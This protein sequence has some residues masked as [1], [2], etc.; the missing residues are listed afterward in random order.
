MS[1][2]GWFLLLAREMMQFIHAWRS[3]FKSYENWL[4][5]ILILLSGMYLGLLFFNDV[6]ITLKQHLASWTLFFGWI[7]VTLLIGRFPVIGLLIHMSL[8]VIRQLLV[9]LLVFVPVMIAF[10][11]AFHVLLRSS[12]QFENP[13]SSILK[14]LT[15]MLG[16]FEYHEN[17]SWDAAIIDKAYVS[18][19]V[20]FVLSFGFLT[21]IIINL[22][23]GLTVT[24]LDDLSAEAEVIRLEKMVTLLASTHDV[25][26]S[27]KYS[28]VVPLKRLYCPKLEHI[29]K[30]FPYMNSKMNS[31]P[32]RGK[33]LNHLM[34]SPNLI[35]STR[36]CFEPNRK[37]RPYE[38]RS[39]K[40]RLR[41]AGFVPVYLYDEG[42]GD[43][44]MDLKLSLPC[45]LV[46][47][48]MKLI[49]H[50]DDQ[51]RDYKAKTLEDFMGLNNMKQ[52]MKL[53]VKQS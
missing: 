3:Y 45:S 2:I 42:T 20:L 35:S 47:N 6:N 44:N 52:E 34:F 38:E 51:Q 19:Q 23:I 9:C 13:L 25:F 29:G 16:E 17:F 49:K 28:V 1:W 12:P 18:V 7:E 4:E 39:E 26:V 11:L 21:V 46:S 50:K 24:K 33:G 8:Q 30:L 37:K 43:K 22:M 31:V 5:V 14:V 36:I 27:A 15:T 32:K 40:L 10:A 41:M 48:F 53:Q